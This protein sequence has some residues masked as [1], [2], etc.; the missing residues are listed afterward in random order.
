LLAQQL[1]LKMI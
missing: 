1:T